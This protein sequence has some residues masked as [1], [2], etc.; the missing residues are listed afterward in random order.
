MRNIPDKEGRDRRRVWLYFRRSS[1]EVYGSSE[2]YSSSE[3][4]RSSEVYC[5]SVEGIKKLE[6]GGL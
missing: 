6:N 1:S 5:N 2:V 3:I 4:Y